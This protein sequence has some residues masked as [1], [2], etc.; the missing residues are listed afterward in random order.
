MLITV[1]LGTADLRLIRSLCSHAIDF[2]LLPLS[3]EF[4]ETSPNTTEDLRDE[5][6]Y[7]NRS[8]LL[9]LFTT[10]PPV[11]AP[12]PSTTPN[13]PPTVIAQT[14]VAKHLPC[15]YL[16][17]TLLAY[18]P[19]IERPVYRVLRS[20]LSRT[21]HKLPPALVISTLG[22]AIRLRQVKAVSAENKT[23]WSRK[24]PTYVPG[25]LGWQMAAVVRAPGGIRAIMENIFGENAI[26]QNGRGMCLYSTKRSC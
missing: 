6:E 8:L 13:L 1:L 17:A 4:H 10:P 25:R 18:A 20:D 24:W 14:L 26:L 16:S 7:A 19:T 5:L 11:T 9:L 15:V 22:S 2:F 23:G 21:W 3:I 12:G